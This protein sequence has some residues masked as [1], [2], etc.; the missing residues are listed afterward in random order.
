MTVPGPR[1][2]AG[3]LLSC[4]VTVPAVVGVHLIVVGF[5]AVK[6]PSMGVIGF[7]A[8]VAALT[9]APRAT[10]R[11]VAKCILIVAATLMLEKKWMKKFSNESK[12][13]TAM[14]DL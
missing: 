8:E 12:T 3:P 10:T 6:G 13:E 9:S 14:A 1:L 2:L 7:S 4:N 11:K 5:P